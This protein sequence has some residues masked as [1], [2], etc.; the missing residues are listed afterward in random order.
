MKES[1]FNTRILSAEAVQEAAAWLKAGELVAFPTETVYGL[2]ANALAAAAVAKIFAA[3][4]RPADNP[5]IVHVANQAAAEPLARL[6]PL[7][8]QLMDAFWPGPLTLVLPRQKLVP[9]LV[10]AG[11]PT[12]ALRMPRHPLALALLNECGLPLAAPSAN[13]SGRPSPTLPGHVFEDLA[14]QIALILDGGPV[15]IGLESTVLDLSGKQPVLLRPGAVTRSQLQPF[16]GEILLPDQH[17]QERPAAP[18]MKYSH[19]APRA[20]VLLAHDIDDLRQMRQQTQKEGHSP[21]Y[22]LSQES[23]EQLP[24]L[25]RE[26]VLLAWPAHNMEIFANQ[27][28]S[29]FRQ[30]DELKAQAIIVETVPET[31]LGRAIMNRLRKAS[32][33]G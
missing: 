14:G 23:L 29:C 28:F 31:G 5:L 17:R 18:G 21:L 11:L 8:C 12:L 24:E 25:P 15:E 19:Y 6:N 7:A 4:G 16:C 2:G 10:S 27:L 26:Q 33:S 13:L 30:A 3:K 32:G 9:D 1:V 20:R 22:I